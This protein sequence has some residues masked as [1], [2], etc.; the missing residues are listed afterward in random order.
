MIRPKKY[1][2]SMNLTLQRY[3]CETVFVANINCTY[4]FM[5]EY[6]RIKNYFLFWIFQNK[7]TQKPII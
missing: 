3:S 6:I 4:I 1:L 5:T 7:K 2:L